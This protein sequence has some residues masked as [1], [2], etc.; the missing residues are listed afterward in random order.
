MIFLEETTSASISKD[1]EYD[2]EKRAKLLLGG[3][4]LFFISLWT[5]RKSHVHS[6]SDRDRWGNL[7]DD[8]DSKSIE[9]DQSFSHFTTSKKME[10]D[11]DDDDDVG[12]D[13]ND[14]YRLGATCIMYIQRTMSI[15]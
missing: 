13:D 4:C 15:K 2:E 3:I 7:S 11:D 8:I 14:K 10:D 5:C 12:D 9:R 6:I 1:E